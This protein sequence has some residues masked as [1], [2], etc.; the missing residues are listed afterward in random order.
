L[1][2][3][4]ATPA[5]PTDRRRKLPTETPTWRDDGVCIACGANNPIGL[6]LK[7]HWEGDV[8]V[9]TWTPAPEHQGWVGHAHGGMLTLVLDEAMGNAVNTSGYRTPTA[10]LTVRFRHP[11]LIGRPLRVT[12]TRPR[13]RR[14]LTCRA[15]ARD[16]DG[17]LIGEATGKFLPFRNP[18]TNP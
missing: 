11:V 16:E 10:E 6:H 3:N 4:A 18:E 12:A 8:I 17:V 15:E 14:L 7:F 1:R 5:E 13:G 9:T 2:Q